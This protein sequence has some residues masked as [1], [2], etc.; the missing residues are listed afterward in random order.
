MNS[1]S[2]SI[3]FSAGRNDECMTPRYVVE[4][5]VQ[6][7]PE[8]KVYWCP[9]DHADSAFVDVLRKSGREVVFSHIAEGQDFFDYEPERWDVLLSNPPFTSKSRIL[10]R[11]LSFGKPFG[12]LMPLTWLMDAAPKLL[13]GDRQM[14][15]FLFIDRV[16]FLY[17][18][19]RQMDDKVTFGSGFYCWDL[20]PESLIVSDVRRPGTIGGRFVVR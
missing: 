4:A 18:N 20:L 6:Y 9:F 19:G 15:L 16:R 13:Y 8:N 10:E 11:T 5:I 14:Q 17:P 3:L 12:L 2:Q 7:L 1:E